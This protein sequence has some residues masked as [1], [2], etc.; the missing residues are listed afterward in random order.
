MHYRRPYL[1]AHESIELLKN[2]GLAISD[3][4]LAAAVLSNIGYFRFNLYAAEFEVA[5]NTFKPSTSFQDIITLYDFDRELRFIVFKAIEIIETAFKAHISNAM[6]RL[7]GPHWYLDENNFQTRFR[8]DVFIAA[9][10]K[11]CTISSDAPFIAKY[12]KGF[13]APEL[14]PSWMIMEILSIGQVSQIFEHLPSD[15]KQEICHF[16]GQPK[17]ILTSWLH[18]FAYIRNICAHHGKLAYR[19]I[20][21]QLQMP[22]RDKFRFLKDAEDIDT[23]KLYSILCCL[24]FAI[25]SIYPNSVFKSEIL[26]LLN[27]RSIKDL[28]KIGLTKNW[29]VEDIWQ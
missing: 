24:Q 12:M 18:S 21:I 26:Q 28:N 2:R 8:Y 7:Y 15:V 19:K 5:T 10:K 11:D 29:N 17:N 25:N 4:K 23:T 1:T 14:P 9:L 22:S 13:Q 27:N 20:T 3:E 6:S 16:F